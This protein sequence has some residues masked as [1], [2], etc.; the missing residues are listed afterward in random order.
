MSGKSLA[1]EFMNELWNF[2]NSDIDGLHSL[3]SKNVIINSPLGKTVGRDAIKNVDIKWLGAFPDMQL[4]FSNIINE[5]NRIVTTWSIKGSNE[6]EFNNRPATNRLVEYNGTTIFNF[7]HNKVIEYY[8]YIN[9]LDIYTQLGYFLEKE[10][11][12]SQGSLR[13]NLNNLI[14]RASYTEKGAIKLTRQEVVCLSFWASGNSAKEIAILLQISYRT[15]QAHISNIMEK[16]MCH[17]KHELLE[18]VAHKE[19]GH[20]LLDIKN[21]LTSP[22]S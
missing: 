15:V 8:C 10:H 2:K 13:N 1:L 22:R 17:S 6:G 4:S 11:Y 9:L 3:F 19:I 7:S 18:I 5:K 14:D 16:F 20:I 21:I 12:P